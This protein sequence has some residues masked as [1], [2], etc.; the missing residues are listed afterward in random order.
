MHVLKN[1]LGQ[2][3]GQAI[4]N[5]HAA[6]LPTNEPMLGDRCRLE[7]FNASH[8]DDLYDAFIQDSSGHNWT[9][10]PYGPFDSKQAFE[11]WTEQSCYGQDPKFYTVIDLANNQAIGVASYLRIDPN[12][13]VIEVG[14]IHFSPLLQGTTLATEVMYLMMKRAFETGYRRYEWKCD[15]LNT[16]SKKAALRLGFTSEG[17]FRQAT[18]YKNRN[19]DT[20]WFSLLDTEW[21]TNQKAFEAWLSVSNF[22][23][24]GRQ[25]KSLSQCRA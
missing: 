19:R 12:V 7:P 14:H 15:T 21:P 17:V 3:V 11:A 5:W 16:P 9:Y 6:T 22:D 4:A 18:M 10:L 24:N 20:A 1:N 2:V 25:I 23:D 8:V 13:G